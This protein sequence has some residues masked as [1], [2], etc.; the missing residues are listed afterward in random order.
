MIKVGVV[1]TVNE[2]ECTARVFFPDT[3]LLS[4]ELQISYRGTH[5][6]KY[7]WLPDIEEQVICAFTEQ[8]VGYILASLYSNTDSPPIK[9]RNKRY[10]AFSDGTTI[11]YDISTSTLS[12]NATGPINITATGDINVHGD[13]IADG[14]SLKKHTHTETNSVTSVPIGSD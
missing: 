9:D 4:A 14:I 12:I 11:E 5:G 3:N 1:K 6:D 7:Y 2:K 13:V 8:K 10:I